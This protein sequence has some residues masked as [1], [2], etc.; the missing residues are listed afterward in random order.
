MTGH[1]SCR[2]DLISTLDD[3]QA[4][5][6]YVLWLLCTRRTNIRF[7]NACSSSLPR[8]CYNPLD[9]SLLCDP[10][11]HFHHI[12]CGQEIFLFG[13][14]RYPSR[15]RCTECLEWIWSLDDQ[16]NYIIACARGREILHKFSTRD[17]TPRYISNS[18]SAQVS[19]TYSLF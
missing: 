6:M 7:S 16:S 17:Q 10:D 5:G 3:G 19:N 15:N 8:P 9:V 18:T 2:F 1:S 4:G 13:R 14:K 12:Y 11:F